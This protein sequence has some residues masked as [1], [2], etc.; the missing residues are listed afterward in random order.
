MKRITWSPEPRGWVVGIAAITL[1]V[2]LILLVAPSRSPQQAGSTYGR[3]PDGYGA[4]YAALQRQGTPIQRW[5][6]PFSQLDHLTASQG[7]TLLRIN[8]SPTPIALFGE[9]PDWVEQGNTLIV[10]GVQQAVTPAR[11]RSLHASPAGFV[12]IETRRRHLP[13][14]AL[15]PVPETVLLGDR[16]GAI[17][18]Q[19]PRGKGQVIFAV[20]PHLA[21][22]AYQQDAGNFP[23]L[24]Q[25]VTQTGQPIWVNEYIHGYRDP[26]VQ[27]QEGRGNWIS[28]LSQTGWFWVA[29]QGGVLLLGLIWAGNRRL[30][31]I[32][33]LREPEADNNQAY[34][35]AL[36]GV[37]RQ[38]GSHAFVLDRI[39]QA[40]KQRLQQALGLGQGPIA[41]PTLMA[42]WVDQTGHPTTVLE[43][44]LAP[45]D[46]APAPISEA[47]LR[48]WLAALHTLQQMTRTQ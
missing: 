13:P 21:A 19:Q 35:E 4:W 2:L 9:E 7:I 22:N 11:F 24:T 32:V 17:V 41:T 43:T 25:L 23:F 44:F 30:G 31:T 37:L 26:E 28:Y 47:A 27:I 33:R 29:I 36:A 48:D 1:L 6:K 46:S 18:W 45:L 34:I 15:P 3:T 38:A 20:T 39:G 12:R 5:Q 42:A 14:Q 16:F 8:P 10:L 40:E